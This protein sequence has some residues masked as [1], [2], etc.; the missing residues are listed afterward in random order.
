MR[1]PQQ[2]DEAPQDVWTVAAIAVVAYIVSNVAHEGLGHGGACLLAGGRAEMLN[3]VFFECDLSRL[4]PQGTRWLAAGGTL[5]NLSL[6]AAAWL[7]LRGGQRLGAHA[8][9]FLWLLL[10][11]NLLQSF[12]YLMFSGV[13][14]VGDWVTVAEGAGPVWLWR[15]GLA[16]LGTWLYFFIAPR[17]FLP[18]LEDFL[19]EERPLRLRRARRLTLIPY[20]AGG[21]S[22]LAAGVFNPHGIVLVLISAAAA[23]FGGTSLLA[24]YPPLWARKKPTVPSGTALPVRRS[25]AWL[26][27]AALVLGV[28]V[29]VLGPGVKFTVS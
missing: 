22:Y 16:L 25:A 8:R 5:A 4:S 28:F 13:A 15:C 24:W 14:G 3:A 2:V 9:Y 12:G 20:L 23:S 11:V 18:R 10:A 29:A 27:T 1:Q 21:L 19:G 7:G 17:L 26:V 6:A